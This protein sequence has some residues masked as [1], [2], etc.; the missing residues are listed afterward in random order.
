[1]EE[2]EPLKLTGVRTTSGAVPELKLIVD[3]VVD[4][5]DSSPADTHPLT[6]MPISKEF[7]HVSW[8]CDDGYSTD[9]GAGPRG[10][11]FIIICLSS[12]MY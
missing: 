4:T 1:M 8:T 12:G 2:P 9:S 7:D 11:S 10:M 6:N 3:T 5:C